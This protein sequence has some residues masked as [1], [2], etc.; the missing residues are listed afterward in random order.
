MSAFNISMLYMFIKRNLIIQFP[1][2]F[3]IDQSRDKLM[4][5]PEPETLDAQGFVHVDWISVLTK[6]P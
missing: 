6:N 3:P 1:P 2:Y 5:S 4:D